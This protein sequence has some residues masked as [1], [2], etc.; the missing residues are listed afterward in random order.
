MV[1]RW[2]LQYIFTEKSTQ[3]VKKQYIT[4]ILII[5]LYNEDAKAYLHGT[6]VIPECGV[7]T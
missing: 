6:V 7:T 3:H 4:E 1:S 2:Q 5:N